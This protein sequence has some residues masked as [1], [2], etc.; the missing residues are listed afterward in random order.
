MLY[1]ALTT[2]QEAFDATTHARNDLDVLSLSISQDENE[3]ARA[4][5]EIQNPKGKLRE[6][7]IL[8]S[9]DGILLFRGTISSV[10][11]GDSGETVTIEAIARPDNADVVLQELVDGLKYAPFYDLLF[12]PVGEENDPSEVLAGHGK[13]LAWDRANHTVDAADILGGSSS[14]T[15]EPFFNSLSY[16]ITEDIPRSASIVANVSWSQ[17]IRRSHNLQTSIFALSTMTPDKLIEG[18]PKAGDELSSGFRVVSSEIEEEKTGL[19]RSMRQQVAV[20]HNVASDELDPAFIAEGS[21]VEK[22]EIVPLT[23]NLIVVSDHSVRRIEHASLTL[24]AGI[25]EVLNTDAIDIEDITLRDIT[26]GN[27]YPGWQPRVNYA[28]GD[29]VVCGTH[30]YRSKTDHFSS[31]RFN[32]DAWD[33]L[34]E[35]AYITSQTSDSFFASSRG[36]DAAEHMKARAEA[37]LRYLSRAV[38]VSFDCAMPNPSLITADCQATVIDPRFDGGTATGRVISYRLDWVNGARTASFDVAC[39][40]GLGE[41][42]PVVLNA[43]DGIPETASVSVDVLIEDNSENQREAFVSGGEIPPTEISFSTRSPASKDYEISLLF[44]A[45]GPI[46]LPRQI[47]LDGL[48]S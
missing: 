21:Y 23:G 27:G 8:I 37:R 22:A 1:F 3:I 6:R 33:D 7:K 20:V 36:A 48:I 40:A 38:V 34:G 31:F 28:A 14:V 17:R 32:E 35:A 45:N 42:E 9:E 11:R 30:E 29:V 24:T 46:S 19:G 47:N 10:P 18:F 5:M 4:E 16:D 44:S 25:Q 39:C 41:G 13:V 43:P 15:V 2:D 26:V 12:I